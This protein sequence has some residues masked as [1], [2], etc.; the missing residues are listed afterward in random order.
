M[1]DPSYDLNTKQP[2]FP[3]TLNILLIGSHQRVVGTQGSRKLVFSF[4]EF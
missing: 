4:S 2:M 3:G 1:E